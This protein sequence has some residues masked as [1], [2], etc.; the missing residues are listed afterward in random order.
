MLLSHTETI[1]A[2]TA[3][4]SSSNTQSD[5]VI[6]KYAKEAIFYLDITAVSGTSPT[7]DI[8]LQ[9]YDTVIEKWFTLAT[10]DQKSAT[11]QDVGYVE[12]GLGEK[13]A[14]SYTI[15]GT[16]TPTFT[17]EITVNLKDQT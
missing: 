12:Y 8:T 3:V 7:L 14:C 4:T 1:L 6:S 16:G 2:S 17:F 9:I 13:L 15:G 11:G 5:P 10:F